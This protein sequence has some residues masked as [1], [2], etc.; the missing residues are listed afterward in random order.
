MPGTGTKVKN[1]LFTIKHSISV[2]RE[3]QAGP[4]HT[5]KTAKIKCKKQTS[6][7]AGDAEKLESS[8]TA[9]ESGKWG[10]SF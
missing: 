6:G 7:V 3:I 10:S 5:M 1:A 4:L 9:D 2:I 8:Y